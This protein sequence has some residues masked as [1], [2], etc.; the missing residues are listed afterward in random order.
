MSNT[1]IHH[2]KKYTTTAITKNISQHSL[3]TIH[4]ILIPIVRHVNQNDLLQKAKQ[5][6]SQSRQPQIQP[7]K[8][9]ITV[10]KHGHGNRPQHHTILRRPHLSVQRR[11]HFGRHGR[12]RKKQG[13]DRH[14][15][16]DARVAHTHLH[17]R[18]RV[19]LVPFAA[20]VPRVVHEVA[21]SGHPPERTPSLLRRHN[22]RS[23]GVLK[24]E[25]NQRGETEEED[26][27][28]AARG[29][30]GGAAQARVAERARHGAAAV[31]HTEGD[32]LTDGGA[33][34]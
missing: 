4:P 19:I 17:Q 16:K 25:R 34:S 3:G 7:G 12:C 29:A 20:V 24:P 22:G 13:H 33:L 11:L 2:T 14:G 21:E 9:G 23:H 26:G 31:A 10:H 27:S 32:G 15:S 8:Q 28:F 30:F 6:G 5:H 1:L 18:R